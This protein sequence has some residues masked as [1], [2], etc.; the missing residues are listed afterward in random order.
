[1]AVVI[2]TCDTCKRIIEIPR[3]DKGLEVIQRCVITQGCRGKLYQTNLKVDYVRGGFPDPVPGLDD[4]AQRRTLF[5]FTQ[6]ISR[7]EWFI[8]H[9]LG[10]APAIQ[11]FVISPDIDPDTG[12]EI[13][14]LTEI[15]PDEVEFVDENNLILR[16]NIGQKGIA[17][18]FTLTTNPSNVDPEIETVQET[19]EPVQISNSL[20][21][22][23]ATLA[24]TVIDGNIGLQISFTT[25]DNTNP[26]LTYV[27]D[28]QPSILSPWN[29][30]NK[31]IIR[32]K[33]YIVRSFLFSSQSHT[34]FTTGQINNGSTFNF[35]EIN[36]NID[37]I[38][39]G[40]TP[41]FRPI[42]SKE[43][44][45]L[46]AESPFSNADKLETQ[47]I[48]VINDIQFAFA[49]AVPNFFADYSTVLNTYPPI[50]PI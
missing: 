28:N 8:Q 39:G 2:Y 38:V 31:V 36:P 23:I 30:V 16:F 48:D 7:R 14:K 37:N 34:E 10:V 4:W 22:S 13:E 44:L 35:T 47:F 45:I 21:I 33:S 32:G 43:V 20:S 18:L 9:N 29:D 25:L 11:V 1:M 17:Q 27:I 24:S 19:P 49:Y 50:R 40:P 42:N 12:E 15:Q 6:T 46:L 41:G 3:N 5:N 26:V